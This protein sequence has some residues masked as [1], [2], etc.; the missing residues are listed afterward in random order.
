VKG[1]IFGAL[2]WVAM[3]LLFFPAL[4]RGL[5]ALEA[6]LGTMPALFSLLMLLT[7]GVV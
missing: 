3:G 4:G 5:F 2:G 7:Y 1:L 6:G